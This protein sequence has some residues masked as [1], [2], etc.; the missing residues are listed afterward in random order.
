MPVPEINA[1]DPSSKETQ[2]KAAMSACIATE[3]RA[4][5]DRDQAVEICRAMLLKRAAKRTAPEKG[6]NG[7]I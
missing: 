3:V 2:I 1:L 6:A 7:S 4:G 5:R